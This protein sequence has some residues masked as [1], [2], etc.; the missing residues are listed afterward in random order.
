MLCPEVWNFKPP[1]CN[2]SFNRVPVSKLPTVV[3]DLVLPHYF[4]HSVSI[5][6]TFVHFNIS[7]DEIK[8]MVRMAWQ[9]GLLVQ[10]YLCRCEQLF[11]IDRQLMYRF[12]GN[13]NENANL[14]E[15]SWLFI[16][17]NVEQ[18]PAQLCKI[19]VICLF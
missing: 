14:K 2:S 19:V 16:W 10:Y 4:N 3:D 12:V 18:S 11:C 7:W 9:L 8:H 5:M 13:T 1:K 17:K 15:K 6:M